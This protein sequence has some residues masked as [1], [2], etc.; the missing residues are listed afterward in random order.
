VS[1]AT[2]TFF[3]LESVATDRPILATRIGVRSTLTRPRTPEL[4][5]SFVFKPHSPMSSS[6]LN[7][8]MHLNNYAKP[9]DRNFSVHARQ[10]KSSLFSFFGFPRI[11]LTVFS[12][13]AFHLN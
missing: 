4:P 2:S 6:W 11:L 8:D 13:D 9:S 3:A 7:R 12:L 10:R 5:K 1:R